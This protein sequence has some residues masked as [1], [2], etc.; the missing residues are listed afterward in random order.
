M[1]RG[2]FIN[3]RET[4]IRV[5]LT[6][7][8]VG[9]FVWMALMFFR[10]AA[11]DASHQSRQAA[12]ASVP[13]SQSSRR[14]EGDSARTYLA[15][16]NDGESLMKAVELQQYGLKRQEHSPF[17]KASG[18]GYLG[19]SHEENLNVW[20]GDEGAIIRPTLSQKDQDQSW[21]LEM[22]LKA[23]GYG[24]QLTTAPPIVSHNV[25]DSRIEYARGVAANPQS[26]IRN[27]QLVE[28]YVN[29]SA[30]LEQGF[31]LNE[32][33][34][35][36]N[37][38]P[39]KL[40]LAVNGDLSAQ[41]TTD[42]ASIQLGKNGQGILTYSHLVATDA[43][44][45]G[46]TATMETNARGDEIALVVDDGNAQY[47]IMI[48]PIAATLKQEL[49]AA[50]TSQQDARFGFAVALD[51][52]AAVVGAW[53]EDILG[54]ADVGALYIFVRPNPQANW[55][56]QQK[57]G[58]AAASE[59]EQC[60]TSVGILS[61]VNS[62]SYI[63]YGCP[64]A[65]SSSGK[66]FVY[67]LAGNFSAEIIPPA[68][69]RGPGAR[70]GTSVAFKFSGRLVA[71]IGEPE[72]SS[73]AITRNGAALIFY[74]NPAGLGA[75]L[76][77]K[78]SGPFTN[79][80]CGT[81]VAIDGNLVNAGH[82]ILIGCPGS[83]TV[84]ASDVLDGGGSTT[85]APTNAAPDTG[86]GQ[87]VALYQNKA[88]I[89]AP[90]DDTKGTDAG[91][92]YVFVR[93]TNGQWSQQQKLLAS[94]GNAGD[95]FSENAVAI[96]GNTMVVGAYGNGIGGDPLRGIPDDDRGAAYIFTHSSTDAGESW[97]QQAKLSQNDFQGGEAGDHFG[98]DVDISGT[99]VLI[100]ARAASAGSTLRA[101][102]AF[103]YELDCFSPYD[104][105]TTF[106]AANGEVN[107]TVCPGTTLAIYNYGTFPASTTIQWRKLTAQG[108]IN[109]SS[110]PAAT[111]NTLIINRATASDAGFY[112]AVISSPC[113]V[114]V[115]NQIALNVS[116]FTLN[117]S[118]QNIG[119]AGSKGVINVTCTATC[120]Y[121]AVP[122]ASW[123]TITSGASGNS[124]STVGFTVAAN[125]GPART[126]T[127]TIGGQTFTVTQ[128]G[129]ASP[130]PTPTPSPTATPT[131]T[132][133]PAS[134]VVQFS[135]SNYSVQED[136]TTV[137]LTVNRSGDTSGAASVDYNTVDN[138]ASERRDYITALGKLQFAPG[139]TSK[140]I[141]VLINEDSLVEGNETFNVNL[142][143][144]VGV[145]LGGQW[146]AT[147]TIV[148]DATEPAT[149][150]IDDAQ[151]FV[152]QHYHD[153][154]N[155]QPDASGLAFW[156][157][158]ITACGTDTACIEN[159]RINV[160]AAFYLS[161]EF[162]E[163]GYLVERLYRTAY[164]SA[165]GSSNFP[166]AHQLPVPVVRLNEFLLDTQKIGQGVVVGQGNWQQ[167]LETNK[168]NFTA[169]FVQ[170]ARFTTTF[171]GS[172]SATQFVDTLNANAGNP[173]SQSE[174]DQLVNEL[175][176]NVK[177]R[178][179]VLRAVAEDADL[180][181]SESNRAFVLMQ[182]FGYLR[183]N[184]NDPQDTDYTGY[185]FW[186]TKLNQFNGNFQNAEMVK[187]FTSSIEYRQRFG[188]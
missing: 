34:A 122:N 139:E 68:G 23:Y 16:T 110:S 150:A 112:D 17:D 182:F 162:Q 133:T 137:T 15:Q 144:P 9:C 175:A 118:F 93:G 13:G 33:P 62:R 80:T 79:G 94:D 98:I 91:A 179:Q 186:L 47:P 24:E 128:D 143:N 52:N 173:L 12:A 67:D 165:N 103:S 115:T 8:L 2:E 176:A 44:G 136:C 27:P 156:T 39:L 56:F 101:G 74:I 148:D 60:G 116:T 104:L 26:A 29:K 174:R 4:R 102:A 168:Q 135:A 127:I 166:S 45:N 170:R 54:T 188:P 178:A 163:T 185:D 76:L 132:P 69:T 154:L 171:P 123:I 108:W 81:S 86:F 113:G 30:G 46:L 169:D 63:V 61:R 151:T 141:V 71:A 70:F 147:V 87:S 49:T 38:G 19:L 158:N 97:M 155:R 153:F 6:V 18:A 32:R 36:A 72:D 125:S 126:G 64:G 111:P 57:L 152:C 82:A 114:E 129:A 55:I 77:T 145:S 164:G 109:I 124:P 31:T 117:P 140:T 1:F 181:A 7:G 85:L 184:P 73:N 50:S 66:A 180:F 14:L 10:R 146:I 134:S 157:S 149:N 90:L 183:R 131:P 161:I 20:F 142:S 75:D 51:L 92:A 35:G 40:V 83:D 43:N 105:R 107:S 21:R 159:R 11:H 120:S 78:I 130:S 121:T 167:Q 5:L 84:V 48:D 42:G 119:A 65:G 96:E 177:T 88:V 172:M 59:A 25:K 99:T 53:R 95:H 138:T 37:E 28:W 22:K 3:Q 106:G 58:N 187:A 89:G 41:A 100:G 160:S